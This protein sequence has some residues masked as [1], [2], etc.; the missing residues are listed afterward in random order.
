VLLGRPVRRIELGVALLVG[1]LAFGTAGYVLVGLPLFDAFY[2]TAIT[3]STVGYGEIGPEGEV[4]RAY[5]VVTLLLVFGGAGSVVYTG[6]VVIETFVEGAL[7][8][9]L[10]RRRMQRHVDAMRDHVIVAGW[11][12]VGRSI[13]AYAGRHGLPVV[14]VDQDP[15]LTDRD[16]PIVVGDATDEATL[17]AAGIH[18]ASSLIAALATDSDN[19]ALALTARSL[20]ADLVIVCRVAEPRSERKFHLAGADHVVNPYEIGGARMAAIAFRPHVAEFLD[21]VIHAEEQD[22]DIQEVVVAAGSPAVGAALGTV[23]GAGDGQPTASVIAMKRSDGHYEVNPTPDTALE[24]GDVLIA[25]GTAGQ[26]A[27]LRGAAG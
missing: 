27:R 1:V 13:A 22:V 16:V 4:D 3:V 14:A 7:E 11:G 12:R 25:V 5:R 23:T 2:Q 10:G 19:L 21:E 6:S 15:G 18:R 26:L 24:A 8:R 20:R 9:G 17:E